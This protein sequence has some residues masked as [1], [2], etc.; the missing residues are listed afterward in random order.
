ML[1]QPKFV[2]KKIKPSNK[3]IYNKPQKVQI[4]RTNINYVRCTFMCIS[5][6]ISVLTHE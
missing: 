1:I 4:S 2:L 6:F 5:I 3:N